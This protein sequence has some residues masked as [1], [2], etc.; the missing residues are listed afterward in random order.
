[1]RK[2]LIKLCLLFF[3]ENK[4]RIPLKKQIRKFPLSP[5]KKTKE[6]EINETHE[7]NKKIFLL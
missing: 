2:D 4:A 5:V 3:H 7:L 6:S 1:M